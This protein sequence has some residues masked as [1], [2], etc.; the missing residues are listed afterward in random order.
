MNKEK[1]TVAI[2]PGEKIK[3]AVKFNN[4]GIYMFHCRIFL[5]DFIFRFETTS[6]GNNNTEYKYGGVCFYEFQL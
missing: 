4:K 1:D 3:L 6:T 2:Q 5:G